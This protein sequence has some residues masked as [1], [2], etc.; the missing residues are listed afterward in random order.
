MY[1]EGFILISLFTEH[2]SPFHAINGIKMQAGAGGAKFAL[3]GRRSTYDSSGTVCSADD[4]DHSDII[5]SC[6]FKW[7]ARARLWS[8]IVSIGAIRHIQIAA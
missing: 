5:E 6:G 8:G 7:I 1:V 2:E 4:A 3:G